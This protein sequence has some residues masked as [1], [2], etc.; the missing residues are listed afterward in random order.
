MSFF[1]QRIVLFR[2]MWYQI[3]DGV[4]I[5]RRWVILSSQE[6]TEVQI[7]NLK[8][9]LKLYR[10]NKKYILVIALNPKVLY[11]RFLTAKLNRTLIKKFRN[12]AQNI[13]KLDFSKLIFVLSGSSLHCKV[14]T[15]C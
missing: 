14:N 3:C 10:K 7:S 8:T 2:K 1:K 12:D 15:T 5:Q 11:M 9:K 4:C 13:R 6:P